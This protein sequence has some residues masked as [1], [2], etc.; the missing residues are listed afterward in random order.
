MFNYR[1]PSAISL[2]ASQNL[3]NI[4]S[5]YLLRITSSSI[6]GPSL[7]SWIMRRGERLGFGWEED[8]RVVITVFALI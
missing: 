8:E 6:N 4:I 2:K 3:P 1:K 7:F 5:S